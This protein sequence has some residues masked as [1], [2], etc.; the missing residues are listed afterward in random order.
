MYASL[1]DTFDI[2]TLINYLG[3]T[4]VGNSIATV[5]N[6]TDPWV[7]PS[8]Y[9]P[10]V[11]LSVVEVAYQDIINTTIDPVLIPPTVSEESK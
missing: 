8:H 10:E 1:M 11:S 5:G 6:R 9:E 2:R 7:L 3:S 4:S